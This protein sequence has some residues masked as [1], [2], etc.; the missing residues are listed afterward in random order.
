MEQ[1]IEQPWR[2][3]LTIA[4]H[5][6]EKIH[7]LAKRKGIKPSAVIALM[8]DNYPDCNQNG[9]QQGTPSNA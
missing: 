8:V 2:T 7:R 5:L 4:P 9:T 1:N 6:A 3:T